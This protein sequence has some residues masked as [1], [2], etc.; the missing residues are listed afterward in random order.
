MFIITVIVYTILLSLLR[1][2]YFFGLALI[3][4]LA[5]FIPYV[6][7][8]VTWII[9]ALVA[10]FSSTPIFGM[11]PL[12]YAILVVVICYLVDAFM[13][14]FVATRMMAS[15][16]NIHP[17]AVM[18]AALVGLNLFGI[19]GVILAAPI[20]ATLLLIFNYAR[21][22]MIDEDPWE[23][24]EVLQAQRKQPRWIQLLSNLNKR[25]FKAIKGWITHLKLVIKKQNTKI[26]QKRSAK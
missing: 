9:Y 6:G 4:G 7:P 1:V 14:T 18:I 21:F 13:D 5:R 17:A 10:G 12:G 19:I 25:I 2:N 11:S 3:A 24:I 22:K 23:H 15:A 16:L 26:N 8:L 20:L